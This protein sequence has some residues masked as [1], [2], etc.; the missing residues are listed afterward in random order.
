MMFKHVSLCL[1]AIGL[2]ACAN[3]EHS[4]ITKASGV[5]DSLLEEK[6]VSVADSYAGNPDVQR[7]ISQLVEQHNYDKARLE[8]AF[9]HIQVRPKV[10]E[11]SDN[12]P[13]VITPFYEY[14]T[15]FVNPS[16]AK[17]GREFAKRNAFWLRKAEQ[18]FGVDSSVIVALIGVETYYGRITGSKDVFTS[19][20]TLAFDYP[21][22][23]EYFQ[24]ELEAYLLLAREEGWNIGDTKG[25]YSGAMG[26][27]Q[28]MPSNYRKLA[29]DYDSDGHIDLW[30]SDADAIGSV[31]N[32]LKHHKWQTDQPWFVT[33]YVAEPDM[34]A[35]DINRGRVPDVD[36]T[37]WSAVKVLPT[38]PFVS[39]KTGLIG[40]Q[41]GPGEMSYWLAYENFFT[42]MDYNP[43]RRY[44]MSVLELAK[45]IGRY[46]VD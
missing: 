17:L 13:E 27:V 37:A 3:T 39:E 44:A 41:T 12:Q 43:S 4:V 10:I 40:L 38:Q 45:S 46:E 19:L 31:A 20:T 18:D 9:S 28:F 36:I 30:Q 35:K 5:S 42:I 2:T 11:K 26:M 6:P 25:S 15:R 29:I 16:R 22:R 32:Y 21:R 23:K 8:L 24:S 33:A 1:M 7:F 34:V 14:K